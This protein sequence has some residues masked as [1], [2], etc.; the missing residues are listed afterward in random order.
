MVSRCL[1]PGARFGE[2]LWGHTRTVTFN[3]M[4]DSWPSSMPKKSGV[5]ISPTYSGF[6]SYRSS[7]QP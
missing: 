7:R 3:S 4:A 6:A 1:A 2:A 5:R